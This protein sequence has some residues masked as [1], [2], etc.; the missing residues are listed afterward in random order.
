M[1]IAGLSQEILV[2]YWT[3][4][5]HFDVNSWFYYIIRVILFGSVS[6]SSSCKPN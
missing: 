4:L 6:F 1:Y 3:E 5:V 2:I